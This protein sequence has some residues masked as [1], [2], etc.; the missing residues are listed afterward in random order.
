MVMGKRLFSLGM[1]KI[2]SFNNLSVWITGK[3]K[4]IVNYDDLSKKPNEN[5]INFFMRI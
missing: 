3:L 1:L 2:A 5:V 4:N